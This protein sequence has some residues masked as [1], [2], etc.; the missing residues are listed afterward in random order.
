[1][2][3]DLLAWPRKRTSLTYISLIKIFYSKI[4]N[5]SDTSA[6]LTLLSAPFLIKW[7][8]G[9]VLV[10]FTVILF[11]LPFLTEL[12]TQGFSPLSKPF[13]LFH[14]DHC[15]LLTWLGGCSSVQPLGSNF[16]RS[17]FCLIPVELYPSQI[18]LLQNVDY[19]FY[20]AFYTLSSLTVQ[21]KCYNFPVR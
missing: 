13:F 15:I 14:G 7:M 10:L 4:S 9:L 3:A 20:Q 12:K 5:Q 2:L 6:L 19:L 11:G 1:M 16:E 21:Y 18:W 8:R 17:L